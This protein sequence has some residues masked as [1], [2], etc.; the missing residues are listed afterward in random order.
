MPFL[1]LLSAK[2]KRKLQVSASNSERRLFKLCK[3]D[4]ELWFAS[5]KIIV[6]RLGRVHM[7][8]IGSK[9]VPRFCASRKI[10]VPYY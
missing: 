10:K 8:T 2:M 9:N 3:G 6:S 5:L 7:L 4:Y 1:Q